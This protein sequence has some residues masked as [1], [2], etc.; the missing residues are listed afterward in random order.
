[1]KDQETRLITIH[2]LSKK[3]KD[4]IK[5]KQKEAKKISIELVLE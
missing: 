4:D 2:D 5:E 3:L 1:M